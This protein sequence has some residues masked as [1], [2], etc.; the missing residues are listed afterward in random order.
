MLGEKGPQE[1]IKHGERR[2]FRREPWTAASCQE[3]VGEARTGSPW[4]RRPC[5]PREQVQC[6]RLTMPDSCMAEETGSER[7]SKP[8]KST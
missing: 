8:P 3:E 1:G 7:A 6:S 5:A 4:I 2:V